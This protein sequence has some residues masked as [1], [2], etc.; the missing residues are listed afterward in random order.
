MCSPQ[1]KR[2]SEFLFL[3]TPCENQSTWLKFSGSL[4]GEDMCFVADGRFHIAFSSDLMQEG[5][6]PSPYWFG[7]KRNKKAS[8]HKS[9]TEV[10]GNNK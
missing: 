3:V 6:T 5:R 2:S 4:I 10:T 9:L 7:H 8:W 1:N